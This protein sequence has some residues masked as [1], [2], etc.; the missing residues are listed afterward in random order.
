MSILRLEGVR[1]EIGDFVILD[2][3][4]A[5]LAKGERIGLVGANGAGKTTLLE[6]IAGREESDAGRVHVARGTRVGLLTQEANLERHFSDAPTVRSIVRSGASEVERMERELASLEADGAAA[7]QSPSYAAL[8]E[9]FEAADGYHLDQRVSEALAGLGIPRHRWQGRPAE[10][11]GGE[12]TRV[13]LARQLTADPDLL[14]LDEPTNHLDIAALE[15]LEVTLVRRDGALIVASH[16]RAF[17]DNVVERIWELRDRRLTTFRGG[18]SRYLMQREAADARARSTARSSALAIGREEELVQRYRSQRKHVKMHEHERRLEQLR[19]TQAPQHRRVARLSLPVGGLLGD[20]QGRSAEV[21][22]SLDGVV[23]GYPP[24]RPGA[25]ARAVV[26]VERLEAHRGDRVALVGPNGAGK[27]TLLRSVAGELAALEGFVRVGRN[28]L[29]GYL[30]QLRDRPLAGLSVLDALLAAAPVTPGAARSYLARFLFR[31]ED[32]EKPVS[33]LSGGERSR[34]EL[35]LLG[36]GTVNLL[37]LDEPTNHLDIP[38]REALEAFLRESDATLVIVSHD[39]R[40]LEAVCQRLWVVWPGPAGQPAIVAPFD[41]SYREWRAAVAEGWTAE[42]EL[43]RRSGLRAREPS[44]SPRAAAGDTSAGRDASDGRDRPDGRAASDG[45]AVRVPL[46]A[47]PPGAASRGLPRLSKDAYRREQERIEADMASL[48]ERKMRLEA[49]LG[50]PAVQANFVEL[51][52]LGS[53]LADV[54]AAL[55]QA[56]D[57]WLILEERAPA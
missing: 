25:A 40:L 3:V 13:A 52:R 28:V 31:G 39:R 47:P 32:V 36:V 15:W 50:D 12:Q 6:I 49:G 30:S 27:S 45:R 53:E 24:A 51:R 23:C 29:P 1:R 33:E 2:S 9:R 7:V 20:T 26:H 35:A 55:S 8:R 34:L 5:S 38:A 19:E 44:T 17:L 4:S 18:Y 37:L 48:G 43:R 14:M 56:E 41:G 57:A 54:D 11:S 46:R 22:F 21:A 16:D 10:L 42:V